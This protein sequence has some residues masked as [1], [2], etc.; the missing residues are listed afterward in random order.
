MNLNLKLSDWL[1]TF[2]VRFEGFWKGWKSDL[3]GL[4]IDRL[5]TEEVVELFTS[6]VELL[7]RTRDKIMFLSDLMIEHQA[8]AAQAIVESWL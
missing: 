7:T 8:A 3:K 5:M 1:K 2:L 6:C 4:Y